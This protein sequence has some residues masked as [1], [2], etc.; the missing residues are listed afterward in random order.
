[1]K[2]KEKEELIEEIKNMKLDIKHL[3]ERE[4]IAKFVENDLFRENSKMER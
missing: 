3:K 2:K 4:K 1:V